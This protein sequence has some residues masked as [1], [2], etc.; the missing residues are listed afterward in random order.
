MSDKTTALSAVPTT[1][2]ALTKV[3]SALATPGDGT[4]RA[5]RHRQMSEDIAAL[6]VADEQG[7]VT[8][9]FRGKTLRPADVLAGLKKRAAKEANAWLD[10]STDAE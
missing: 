6:I 7:A 2:T 4:V 8:V 3:R 1:T 5:A 10:E 9:C